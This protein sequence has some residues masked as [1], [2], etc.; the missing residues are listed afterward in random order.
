MRA[1]C[2]IIGDGFVLPPFGLEGTA[3]LTI[4]ILSHR[5]NLTPL[6]HLSLQPLAKIKLQ[7]LMP[8]KASDLD[9]LKLRQAIYPTGSWTSANSSHFALTVIITTGLIAV[10]VYLTFLKCCSRM[11]VTNVQLR[12]SATRRNRARFSP[13]NLLSRLPTP[14]P[15]VASPTA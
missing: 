5:Y 2:K 14:S 8:F 9:F 15:P 10:A 1:G 13:L 6:E 11:L 4:D 12:S 3:N 7:Q